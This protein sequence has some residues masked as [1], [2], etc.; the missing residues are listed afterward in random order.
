MTTCPSRMMS[1]KE[2]QQLPAWTAAVK[3]SLCLFPCLLCISVYCCGHGAMPPSPP[4]PLLPA[5]AIGVAALKGALKLEGELDYANV[6]YTTT[7]MDAAL[8]VTGTVIQQVGGVG[9]QQ[10]LM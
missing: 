4:P 3:M 7:D 10:Q 1:C 9:Q 5:E 2:Q 8:S 6:S